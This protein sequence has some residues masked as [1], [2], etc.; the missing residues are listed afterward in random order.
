MGAQSFPFHPSIMYSSVQDYKAQ[1]ENTITQ[2]VTSKAELLNYFFSA[3]TCHDLY[4]RYFHFPKYRR[5]ETI[6][7]IAVE[8]Y[9]SFYYISV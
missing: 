6:G 5:K 9:S 4:A 8:T 7:T 3:W 2:K 1:R